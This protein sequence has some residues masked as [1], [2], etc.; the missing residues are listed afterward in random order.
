[1]IRVVACGVLA[2]ALSLAVRTRSPDDFDSL[3][4][5]KQGLYVVDAYREGRL[6]VPLEGGEYYPTKPP[7]MTWLSLAIAIPRGHVDELAAR[8]PSVGAALLLVAGTARFARRLGRAAAFTAT[9][10]VASSFHVA[11]CAWQARPDMLLAAVTTF[12]TAQTFEAFLVSNRGGDPRR[13][14]VAAA[15]LMGLG[16]VAKSPVALACPLFALGTFLL[17]TGKTAPFARAIGAGT[18]GLS[19]LAYVLV[20]GAW[21]VPAALVGGRPFVETLWRELVGH[22]AATGDYDDKA[23]PFY[24]A[25]AHFSGKFLPWSF[26]LGAG[27]LGAI[28][29]SARSRLGRPALER[30]KLEPAGDRG[31]AARFA[32]SALVGSLLFFSLLR[33][34]R[35]DHVLPCYPWAAL[36]TGLVVERWLADGRGLVGPA[37]GLVSVF[38]MGAG[39]LGPLVLRLPALRLEGAPSRALETLAQRPWLALPAAFLLVPAG[40]LLLAGVLRRSLGAVLSGSALS[41]SLG[42][43]LYFGGGDPS[44]AN[45]KAV[46]VPPFARAA[47]RLV[48]AQAAA[49][50]RVPSSLPFY[51]ERSQVARLDLGEALADM[52]RGARAVVT[53]ETGAAELL[54]RRSDLAL[55]ATSG[56]YRR[57][58]GIFQLALLLPRE[59]VGAAFDPSGGAA[60]VWW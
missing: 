20:L 34:K 45:Q 7:L 56:F 19:A 28:G 36:A 53:D 23:R 17:A 11:S 35:A 3:D 21:F 48:G 49:F 44:C 4:Q 57:S 24:Y 10:A 40:V 43:A 32:V 55:A 15:A 41:V 13:S 5:A 50:Y 54:A 51:F 27:A 33:V 14:F 47:R 29:A 59:Q 2:L 58:N 9:V 37:L 22:A 38:V 12:A 39:A 6:L 52:R 18:L 42:L 30:S 31:L 25:L 60:W 8:L 16:T 46:T 1:M 26:L